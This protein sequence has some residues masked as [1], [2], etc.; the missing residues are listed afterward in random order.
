MP[1]DAPPPSRSL[2]QPVARQFAVLPLIIVIGLFSTGLRF[3][4]RWV[5]DSYVEEYDSYGITVAALAL[6]ALGAGLV[7]WLGCW[8]LLRR[9]R[10]LLVG[11]V[12]A[13]LIGPI[14]VSTWSIDD[15]LK[16][17]A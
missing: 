13:V 11:Q 7:A 10:A 15:A 16:H 17:P 9:R 12:I 14:L 6:A 3:F 5:L 2:L 8:F 4:W 1:Q